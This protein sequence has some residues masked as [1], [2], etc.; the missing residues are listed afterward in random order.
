MDEP[1]P[2]DWIVSITSIGNHLISQK[3]IGCYCAVSHS[4]ADDCIFI[5]AEYAR[6]PEQP[7][8]IHSVIQLEHYKNKGDGRHWLLG[9]FQSITTPTG[10]IFPLV[11]KNG[12]CYLTQ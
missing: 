9:G 6:V 1:H 10:E 2:S 3:R 11:F 8:S 12:L 5:Y 4:T 7:T